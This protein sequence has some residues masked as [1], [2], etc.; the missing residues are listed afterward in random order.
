MIKTNEIEHKI[1]IINN[2]KKY[3]NNKMPTKTIYKKKII[4]YNCINILNENTYIY[5]GQYKTTNKK[6][7]ELMKNLT[8]N[9]FKFGA[10]SQKIIRN[11]WRQNKLITYKQFSELWINENNIGI[12][13][14][15]LAYNEFMK[16]NGNKDEWHQNKKAILIL[17]KKFNLLN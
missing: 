12:K 4:N 14:A 17:F 11:I 7:L 3:L 2:I 8:Y 5:Y 1:I 16:T 10:I 6:I 9:K 15:E 13:Y